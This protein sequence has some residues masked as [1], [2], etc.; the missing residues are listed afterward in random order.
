MIPR[1]SDNDSLHERR[2]TISEIG[3]W[4]GSVAMRG[5]R[6]RT[7]TQTDV[8][9][10]IADKGPLKISIARVSKEKKWKW[11]DKTQV[12]FSLYMK[13]M[14]KMEIVIV[15]RQLTTKYLHIIHK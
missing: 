13:N 3:I 4:G 9:S 11:A 1:D 8:R 12:I 15:Y 14:Y 10:Q 6:D 2:E 7:E 5:Y